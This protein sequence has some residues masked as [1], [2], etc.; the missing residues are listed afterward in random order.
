[1]AE[2]NA[3]HDPR[4]RSWVRSANEPGC[5]FPIQNLP[6]GIFRAGKGP[7]RAG[8]A[9]GD[10][11]LDV[12]ALLKSGFFSGA[13]AEA[14]RAASGERLNALLAL[15]HAPAS[16]LRAR[17]S[18]LLREDGPDRKKIE[19]QSDR[20][21]IPISAATLELPVTVGS[22]TDFLSSLHHTKRMSQTGDLPPSFKSL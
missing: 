16:A 13:A 11:V 3:T 8:V 1:M 20:L 18:D 7:A 6:F 19:S 17:L 9:I 2:L 5:D 15:G 21:L 14:A 4:R 22:F 12:S 10:R